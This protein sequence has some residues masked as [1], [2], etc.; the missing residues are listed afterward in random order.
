MVISYI[1]HLC[2]NT[3]ILSLSHGLYS[4]RKKWEN[5]SLKRKQWEG[6]SLTLIHVQLCSESQ[7]G[8]LIFETIICGKLFHTEP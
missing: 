5:D 4:I 8:S 7:A 3:E 2:K 1:D 6:I